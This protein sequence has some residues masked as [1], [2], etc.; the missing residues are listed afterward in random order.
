[1]YILK[2]ESFAS[3]NASMNCVF[4]TLMTDVALPR[5]LALYLSLPLHLSLFLSPS[6]SVS[7]YIYMYIYIHTHM[8][9]HILIQIHIKY[10][11]AAEDP[12][13]RSFGGSA[14][15][16]LDWGPTVW[17]PKFSVHEIWS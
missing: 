12:K 15:H 9:I 11:L 16:S 1:M 4:V 17:G 2:A 8:P 6:L 10:T 3:F 13:Q 14:E 7:L 5:S